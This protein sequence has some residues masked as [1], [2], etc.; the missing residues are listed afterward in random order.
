MEAAIGTA[1]VS[2]IIA[3][4]SLFGW[5]LTNAQLPQMIATAILGLSDDPLL[6]LLLINI[7]LL[8]VG[9]FLDSGPAIL[10]MTPILGPVATQIGVDPVQFG[11]IMVINLTIGLLTPPVGTALYVASSISGMSILRLTRALLPFWGIMLSVLML[12]TYWPGFTSW[13]FSK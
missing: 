2:A 9:M 1:V 11:L 12:V 6:L 10:L 5:L 3:A 13:A 4:T 8:I 7:M